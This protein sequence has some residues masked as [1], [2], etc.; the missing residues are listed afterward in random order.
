MHWNLE[1][2]FLLGNT[3]IF[4]EFDFHKYF[5]PFCINILY[6]E[7]IYILMLGYDKINEIAAKNAPMINLPVL[8]L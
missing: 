5:H 2:L 6:K 1:L 8:M 7:L 3:N 4:E